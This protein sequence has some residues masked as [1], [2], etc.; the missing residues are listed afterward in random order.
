MS[1]HS[2]LHDQKDVR[3]AKVVP[4]VLITL[5]PIS[6]TIYSVRKH[7]QSL[8]QLVHPDQHV[9][10]NSLYVH[11]ADITPNLFFL[12]TCFVFKH[13]NY[14]RHHHHFPWYLLPYTTLCEIFDTQ[15]TLNRF[16][17]TF[18]LCLL[19]C[20]ISILYPSINLLHSIKKS[21]SIQSLIIQT[22]QSMQHS[23]ELSSLIKSFLQHRTRSAYIISECSLIK[24]CTTLP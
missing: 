11:L 14:T 15:L 13:C 16:A 7:K 9:Y 1:I 3:M 18:N 5:G 24:I 17:L 10:T 12:K 21:Q 2:V 8:S 19:D 22:L 4:S 20:P 23:C 6:T